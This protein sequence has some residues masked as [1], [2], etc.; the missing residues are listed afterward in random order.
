MLFHTLAEP[1]C[2]QQLAVVDIVEPYRCPQGERKKTEKLLHT[3][4]AA[5]ARCMA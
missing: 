5:A 4:L 1:I 3:V 2:T